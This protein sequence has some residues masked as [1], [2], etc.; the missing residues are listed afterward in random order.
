MREDLLQLVTK[1]H[2][3]CPADVVCPSLVHGPACGGPLCVARGVSPVAR[4]ELNKKQL[5]QVSKIFDSNG[6]NTIDYEEFVSFL[7]APDA[8]TAIRNSKMKKK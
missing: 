3:A 7:E 2:K 6:N 1:K 5:D 8:A 4:F